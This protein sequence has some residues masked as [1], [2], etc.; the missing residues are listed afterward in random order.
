MTT[1]FPLPK[2]Y[3][4]VFAQKTQRCRTRGPFI[5]NVCTITQFTNYHTSHLKC[6]LCNVVKVNCYLLVKLIKPHS[7]QPVHAPGK[8]CILFQK[9]WKSDSSLYCWRATIV[10]FVCLVVL[11]MS[12]VLLIMLLIL[13]NKWWWW[14]HLANIA[15]KERLVHSLKL[16]KK[17]IDRKPPERYKLNEWLNIK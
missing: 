12:S 10:A 17:I 1:D 14:W 4:Y 3:A 9:Y 13:A 15:V 5:I 16:G 6:F 11:Y 7:I 8:E 2:K